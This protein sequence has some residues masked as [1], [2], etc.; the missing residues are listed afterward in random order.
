VT[1]TVENECGSSDTIFEV[2]V[3]GISL[4]EQELGSSIQ[5]F[6]NPTSGEFSV[7]IEDARNR[8]FQFELIDFQGRVID[9]RQEEDLRG[10]QELRFDLSSY[11]EGLYMLRI[12]SEGASMVKRIRRD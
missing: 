1:L 5:L 7:I 11:A 9:R 4:L 6:P 8:D 2:S 3:T 12:S 10:R